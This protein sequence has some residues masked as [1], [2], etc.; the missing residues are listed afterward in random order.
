MRSSIAIYDTGTL[1]G[2]SD[3]RETKYTRN[4]DKSHVYKLMQLLVRRDDLG[5]HNDSDVN[6]QYARGYVSGYS[7]IISGVMA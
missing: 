4:E 6:I 1:A 5:L 3:G 7:S 2:M